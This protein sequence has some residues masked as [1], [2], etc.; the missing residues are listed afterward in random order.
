MIKW[1]HRQR[2]SNSYNI[3]GHSGDKR[4][5]KYENIFLWATRDLQL[6]MWLIPGQKSSWEIW[7]TRWPP[8]SHPT[9][10]SHLESQYYFLK[11]T[12][13]LLVFLFFPD[14]KTKVKEEHNIYIF[15]RKKKKHWRKKTGTREVGYSASM[16]IWVKMASIWVKAGGGGTHP[17]SL[18]MG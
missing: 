11:G 3:F 18:A 7:S 15:T 5:T 4:L 14:S 17:A 16:R 2:R 13:N 12:S 6:F 9:L 8:E 10:D 1:P